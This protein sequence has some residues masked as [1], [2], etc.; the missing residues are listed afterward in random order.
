M[1]MIEAFR[2]TLFIFGAT[3]LLPTQLQ[4]SAPEQNYAQPVSSADAR[5]ALA[6]GRKRLVEDH[7]A[8]GSLDDLKKAVKL[9]PKSVP[10]YLLLGTAYMQTQQWTPAQA[11]FEQAAKLE[12]A[13]AQA[14][15]GIGA[16][17]NQKLDYAGA[18]KALLR[19]LELKTDSAE[20]H[21]ELA[22]TLWSLY[23]FP[24]AEIHVR[25]AIELNPGYSSPH[26]LLANL[27]LVKED[28]E[29]A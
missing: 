16:A 3:L 21:Y 18:Q 7:D 23:K 28:P 10:A 19:S 2:I 13:N 25:K 17:L 5:A 6:Q 12:P 1:H 8:K 24:E 22:R 11:A 9:D 4:A 27:Y 14:Y 20:A 15:L 29:A 26:I